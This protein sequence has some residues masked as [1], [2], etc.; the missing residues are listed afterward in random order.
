[1][2]NKILLILIVLIVYIN[3]NL[4]KANEEFDFNVTEVEITN[5]GNFFKGLKRGVA[6]TNNNQTIITA[7]TFEYDKITNIL[8]A[9]GDVI[10]EDKIKN[11]VIRTN[12][13][14]YF[15]NEEK[16]F[17]KRKNKCNDRVKI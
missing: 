1:M 7:D 9:K 8:I 6:T 16:N 3:S 4:L 13:L 12:H 17:F 10:A 2:K 14:T 11:Y 5:E 15:K